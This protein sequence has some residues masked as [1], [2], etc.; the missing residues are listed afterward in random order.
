MSTGPLHPPI[1]EAPAPRR[2]NPRK[3]HRLA[4]PKQAA[5]APRVGSKFFNIHTARW[6]SVRGVFVAFLAL[7]LW[8]DGPQ[9]Y[10]G[11]EEW[12]ES[13][14]RLAGHAYRSPWQITLVLYVFITA[15][16][17]FL[18]I[19]LMAWWGWLTD[20]WGRILVVVLPITL[21]VLFPLTALDVIKSAG[22]FYGFFVPLDLTQ[23]HF[24]LAVGSLAESVVGSVVAQLVVMIMLGRW[25][26]TAPEGVKG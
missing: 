2:G 12:V 6:L 22:G 3:Q 8:T 14:A 7:W 15:I 4:A 9:G 19:F 24:G 26:K 17:N 16:T 10:W 20:A 21:L 5:P 18:W 13:I 11:T 1:I 23:I 25:G